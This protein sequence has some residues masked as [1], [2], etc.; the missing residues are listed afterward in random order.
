MEETIVAPATPAGRGGVSIIR[1]SGKEAR[2]VG[3]S[4]CGELPEPW[5]FKPCSVLG[6][7]GDLIDSGL[8]VFFSAPKSYTGED[9]VEIHCHGNPLVVDSIMAA[10]V[11]FGA[12][13][14]EPGE[15]TK[16]AFL[17]EKIDLAQA[18]SVADLIAAQ[19][20]S[21]LVAAHSSLSGEFS[22]LVNKTIDKVVAARV[23]V[24]ACLDFSDEESVSVFEDRKQEIRLGIKGGVDDV[25]LLLDGSRVGSKMREG[26][27]VV[28]LGPPNCGKSTLLNRLAR[29]DVAIVSDSPGTTRDLL[30][31]TLDL[32][33]LPVEFVDTA[34]LR[35]DAEEEVE[36]EGMKRALS[37]SDTADLVVLMSCV[38]ENFSPTIPA[39]TKTLR[40]F[41]KIDA[42]PD[43]APLEP[44]EVFISALTGQGIDG[45]VSSV[46]SAFGVGSGIEVPVLARRR[47][48]EGLEKSLSFLLSSLSF[49]DAGEDLV[50]VAEELKEAQKHLGFITRPLTSDELLGHIFSEFCVGK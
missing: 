8:V 19:T 47:H 2:A 41:N 23:L 46:F 18:E 1:V 37:V 22:R 5:C 21:A 7:A 35:T 40:L 31:V 44:E 17:N 50:L 14:A 34:G 3:L 45:F 30:R 15:F 20:T 24:E 27:R 33:G 12:R 42:H 26:L 48:V 28:I 11:F 10:A 36:I 25:S 29:E 32:G 43:Y 9:V 4:L 6:E 39:T 16:R 13:V 49:L 38:G